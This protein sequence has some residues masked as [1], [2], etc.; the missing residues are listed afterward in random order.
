LQYY[1]KRFYFFDNIY[2]HELKIILI[3]PFL[4]IFV[5][6]DQ[7]KFKTNRNQGT[8]KYLKFITLIQQ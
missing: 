3:R 7:D 1:D 2:T 5:L 8:Y 6:R 4:V